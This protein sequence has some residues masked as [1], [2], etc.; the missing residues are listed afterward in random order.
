MAWGTDFD[1]LVMVAQ[2]RHAEIRQAAMRQQQLKELRQAVE[3]KPEQ[4]HWAHWFAGA[5]T[6]QPA[7]SVLAVRPALQK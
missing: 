3:G 4:A 6:R 1:S 7:K 5:K 2:D